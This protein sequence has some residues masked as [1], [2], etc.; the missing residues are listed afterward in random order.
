M[1]CTSAK[2]QQTQL[3][4]PNQLLTL[5]VLSRMHAETGC[6]VCV[7]EHCLSALISEAAAWGSAGRAAFQLPIVTHTEAPREA[8]RGS[9]AGAVLTT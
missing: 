5:V 4:L 9:T 8:L 2:L 7:C 3:Q 6:Q 1:Q